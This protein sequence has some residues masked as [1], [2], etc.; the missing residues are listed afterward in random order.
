MEDILIACYYVGAIVVIALHF[1]GWLANHGAEW[2]VYVAA[3]LLFPMLY[4]AYLP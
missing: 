4:F 1:T 3:V 2:V